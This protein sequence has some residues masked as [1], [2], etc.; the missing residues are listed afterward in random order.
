VSKIHAHL[1]YSKTN[2]FNNINEKEI[3][4][5]Y[6]TDEETIHMREI[7]AKI[8][9]YFNINNVKKEFSTYKNTEEKRVT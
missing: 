7:I 5:S 1:Q 3:N 8:N 6:L 9:L 4:K 2:P